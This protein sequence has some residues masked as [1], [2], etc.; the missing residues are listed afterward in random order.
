MQA[1]TAWKGIELLTGEYA[2]ELRY[3]TPGLTIGFAMTAFAIPA[4]MCCVCFDREKRDPFKKG[5][6]CRLIDGVRNGIQKFAM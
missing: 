3:W 5:P 6:Q 4:I 2:I 1:N